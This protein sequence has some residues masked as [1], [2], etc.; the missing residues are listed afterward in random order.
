MSRLAIVRTVSAETVLVLA[1][2][3]V[4]S[5]VG[6]PVPAAEPTSVAEE[7]RT[8]AT[9][10]NLS[11]EGHPLPLA[12]SWQCGHFRDAS[13]GG[14]RPAN[15]MKLIEAGHHLLPWF[16][17]PPLEGEVSD[18]GEDFFVK[19]YREPI[20]K[21]R[22][23]GLPITFIGSQWE[24]G[25]SREPYLSLPP[26]KNPNVVTMDGKV[27]ERVSP[28]GP[29]GPWREIGAR[30]TNNAWMRKLQEWYPD[31]PLV[32]FLSN[33]EHSKLIWNRVDIARRYVEKY[34]RG[35]DD[36][37]KRKVVADG[38]IERYR[39]LQDGLRRGLN[40]PVWR[41]NAVFVGYDA[42]GP[43][44][45]GRWDGWTHYS[46]HSR[47]R[48]S[49]YPLMWDGGSPSYYTHDWNPSRDDTVWSPQVQFMNL[50]FMQ[51]QAL[52]L[53]PDFWLEFSVWDGYH[54]DPQRQK[55]YPSTRSLYR[56]EGQVYNPQRYGGFVQFGMWLLRPRA[57]RDFRGWTEPWNDVK[58]ARGKVVHEGGGPYFLALVRA[59]DGVYSNPLLRRWWRKGRLVPNRAHKHPYQ[60]NLPEAVKNE[61]RWFLLD[62]D[63]NPRKYPWKL[64]WSVNVFA[65]ALGQG[66]RPHRRW[67]VYA[68]SPHGDRQRV[69]LT[70]PEYKDIAVNVSV[71][72][73][74]YLVEEDADRV[75]PVE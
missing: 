3:A 73:T 23:L 70:V 42:F 44:H 69:K 14:W 28:F 72:G 61:D 40:S 22:E 63:V 26:E 12:C 46:L 54:A 35:R 60:S 38:W 18:E 62:A 41:K 30:Q 56:R 19:Y 9:R 45:I 27:L 37:F 66:E 57:V 48:I 20:L 25:L 51:K 10:P 6:R 31:P 64:D 1:F 39:A 71:G 33:N 29:I 53:N 47:G 65:L 13:C 55:K 17:H 8:E 59:V 34:G 16:A 75:T 52:A 4:W 50:V 49:P 5:C 21:A 15:Q 24:S 67:L 36:E 7:I 74:F 32:I 2:G 11:D 68:H 43:E 58:D